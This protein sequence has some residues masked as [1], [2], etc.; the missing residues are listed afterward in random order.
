VRGSRLSLLVWSFDRCRLSRQNIRFVTIPPETRSAA[1]LAQ[2]ARDYKT[3]VYRQTP[4]CGTAHV[5]ETTDRRTV[6][7]AESSPLSVVAFGDA[8][9][10]AVKKIAAIAFNK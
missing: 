8:P 10:A 9:S 5:R 4:V 2:L 3:L 6:V 1:N 7:T